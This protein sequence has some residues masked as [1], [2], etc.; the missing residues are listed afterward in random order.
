[1]NES[2]HI[3]ISHFTYRREIIAATTV[4]YSYVTWHKLSRVYLWQS[5][6]VWM[7]RV[8]HER[9]M[10]HMNKSCNIWTIHITYK[11][12]T[13]HIDVKLSQLLLWHI[14]MWHDTNYRGCVCDSHVRYG[15]VMPSMNESCDIWTS[16][17][18]YERVIA[19]INA[20][21]HPWHNSFICAA[22]HSYVTWLV[23]M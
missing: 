23:Y 13:S 4:T 19:H 8:M 6:Q 1:M 16:R 2:Y 3:W 11:C 5:C 21:C 14:H 9:V 12:V 20:S 10:W 17:V 18:A 15:W 22:T 7:S